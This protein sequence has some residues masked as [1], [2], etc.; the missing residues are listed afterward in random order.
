MPPGGFD[1]VSYSPDGGAL[2][3]C[4]EPNGGAFLIDTATFSNFAPTTI[5]NPITDSLGVSWG[6]FV[7]DRTLIATTGATLGT[8]ACGVIQ[9][10]RGFQT[11]SVVAFDVVTPSSVVMTAQTPP[12]GN[13]DNLVFSADADSIT[14]LAFAN[15]ANGW[16]GVRVIGSGT[17][18]VTAD[19]ALISIDSFS[20]TIAAI[21]PFTGSRSPN[22]QPNIRDDGS[23]RIFTGQFKGVFDKDGKDLA[24]NGA[25]E[26]RL[27]TRTNSLVVK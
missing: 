9:A 21:L 7:K 16:R 18:V 4:I 24:P 5:S 26:V 17:P 27:D 25:S 8:R 20:G 19:G 10:Q 1:G 13:S 14:K 12:G 3:F 15:S 22:S 11:T 2:A 6:P 23:T